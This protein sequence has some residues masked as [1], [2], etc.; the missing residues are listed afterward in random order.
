MS[1]GLLYGAY[2]N[3]FIFIPYTKI[4]AGLDIGI[5][6]ISAYLNFDLPYIETRSELTVDSQVYSSAIGKLSS[7]DLGVQISLSLN[8]FNDTKY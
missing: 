1:L 3:A 4:F 2:R 5:I 6:N 8:L 7:V